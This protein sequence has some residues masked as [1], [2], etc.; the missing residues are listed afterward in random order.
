MNASSVLMPMSVTLAEEGTSMSLF[1]YVRAGGVLGYVLIALSV[2][3]LALIV[4]NLLSL[5]RGQLAPEGVVT[6][7]S[8]ALRAG[9]V[10]GATRACT[11]DASHSFVSIV[12]ASAIRRCTGNPM[13]AF[14]AR[15][16]I[17]EAGQVATAQLHRLNNGLGVLAAV[18]PMLGLLG[19]V[20]GMIGAFN[21]IGSLQGAAR[22]TELA[23][24]MSLALVNTAQGL[25]VAVPCTVA[26]A[27]F[28][29]R[30]DRLV[31]DVAADDLEPMAEELAAALSAARTQAPRP[32][33]PSSGAAPV[34]QAPRNT[35]AQGN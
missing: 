10:A 4:R 13:G 11:D 19:T 24:F 9:D 31:T 35:P 18:G 20:I 26:F 8:T 21:A 2:L 7:I 22:S 5:R 25:V 29:Q 12:M 17:E 27:L 16:A 28:R 15:S 34:T 14:E 6:A 1:E 32:A 30:I 23:K 3:A 33:V